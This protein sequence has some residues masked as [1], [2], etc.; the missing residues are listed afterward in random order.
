M[1]RPL[2]FAL[3]ARPPGREAAVG[4]KIRAW[5]AALAFAGAAWTV[6]A[7]AAPAAAEPALR[8]RAGIGQRRGYGHRHRI[9]VAHAV[10]GRGVIFAPEIDAANETSVPLLT[11]K[12][13]GDGGFSAEGLR[14][15]TVAGGRHTFGA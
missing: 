2:W 10:R 6:I 1:S 5:M 4:V 9:G 12:V 3:A 8:F 13:D 15:P 7:P 14:V 11:V